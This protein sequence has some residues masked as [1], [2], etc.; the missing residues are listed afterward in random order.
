MTDNIEKLLPFLLHIELR[1]S[2]DFARSQGI[3]EP[4][5]YDGIEY[6]AQ[7]LL[8]HYI[9]DEVI[10]QARFRYEE[11]LDSGK[12]PAQ[13]PEKACIYCPYSEICLERYDEQVINYE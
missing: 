3:P 2:V 6:P 4:Y 8:T 1:Q 5:M 9:N 10:R 12:I 7:R 13:V 11:Y